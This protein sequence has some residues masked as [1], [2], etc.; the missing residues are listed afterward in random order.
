MMS[1]GF[2][3]DHIRVR[4]LKLLAARL[5]EEIGQ[6]DKVWLPDVKQIGAGDDAERVDLVRFNAPLIEQFRGALADIAEETGGR[7][8]TGRQLNVDLDT[9]TNEQLEQLASGKDI[10]SVLRS[11]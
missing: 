1:E 6:E 4:S 8:K 2:A 9:L 10:I 7:Q 11:R 3:L 5:E